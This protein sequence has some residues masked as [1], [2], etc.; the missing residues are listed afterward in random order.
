[1]SSESS[2]SRLPFEPRSKKKK[3]TKS[4]TDTDQNQTAA[5]TTAKTAPAKTAKVSKVKDTS[6]SLSEIPEVVSKRMIR[7]MAIFCGIPT[8]MGL[9]SF[10]VFYWIVRNEY[11]EFP[12]ITVVIVSLGLF[13]LGVLGL[14]YGLF[15]A[16]WD[17]QSEGSWLGW[18][19]FKT[20][21]EE[22]VN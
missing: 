17:E 11:F 8:V 3:N 9:F 5:Q 13:G 19:E 6:T 20:N 1:M 12:P 15:S 4:V 10:F 22:N 16:S 2:R 7:R 18:P 21:F 14:S